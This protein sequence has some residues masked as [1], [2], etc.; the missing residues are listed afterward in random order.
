MQDGKALGDS[1]HLHFLELLL[2]DGLYHSLQQGCLLFNSVSGFRC[3]DHFQRSAS[4]CRC[5]PGGADRVFFSHSNLGGRELNSMTA[6]YQREVNKAGSTSRQRIY[7]RIYSFS[8]CAHACADSKAGTPSTGGMAEQHAGLPIPVGKPH[9][10]IL[11][12]DRKMSLELF[13]R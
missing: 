5:R 4:L 2:I 3:H 11:Y 9:L 12:P 8:A 13:P 10:H 6:N 1:T 7:G